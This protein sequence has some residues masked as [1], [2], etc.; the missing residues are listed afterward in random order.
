MVFI[1]EAYT[2]NS[3]RTGDDCYANVVLGKLCAFMNDHTHDTMFIFAGYEDK[4][5]ESLF[6][7]NAG[8][9]DRLSRVVRFQPLDADGAQQ[10][11]LR[12]AQQQGWA[13]E[14]DAATWQLAFL[15]GSIELRARGS[16]RV[17]RFDGNMSGRRVKNAFD[18][19]R[20]HRDIT[21]HGA[22]DVVTK[23]LVCSAWRGLLLGEAPPIG[24]PAS[25]DHPS[26]NAAARAQPPGE[27]VDAGTGAGVGADDGSPSRA[28]TG[29]GA[30]AAGRAIVAGAGHGAGASARWRV[31][32]TGA[33]G[34]R[35]PPSVALP[36]AAPRAPT[37]RVGGRAALAAEP[38]VE[39]A[40]A[41]AAP[42]L[43]T[44]AASLAVRWLGNG[45]LLMLS[46]VGCW[47]AKACVAAVVAVLP[48]AVVVA[49]TATVVALAVLGVGVLLWRH[50][51]TLCTWW[52]VYHRVAATTQ[53]VVQ[54]ATRAATTA[55]WAVNGVA[56]SSQAAWQA[57][58]RWWRPPQDPQERGNRS[59]S[60]GSGDEDTPAGPEERS[61]AGSPWALLLLFTVT[62]AVWLVVAD[63]CLQYDGGLAD[64]AEL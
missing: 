14:A 38:I 2:L 30:A 9:G 55:R 36:A 19:A 31:S 40:T 5:M 1:D 45:L 4:L 43:T 28:G 54:Q 25:Y 37:P 64:A 21:T 41:Q 33:A 60:P 59:V 63:W 24:P 22:P 51:G 7:A 47:F 61:S 44:A 6:Q 27:D 23:A 3:S 26:P 56:D 35:M 16:D 29:A 11:F 8:L 13:V 15:R 49:A 10:V 20:A 18:T 48:T 57:L 42:D 58:R 32:A 46:T 53:H 17:E 12:Y 34:R 50:W 52:R 39:A 62:A